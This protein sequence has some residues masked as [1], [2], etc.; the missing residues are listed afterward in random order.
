MKQN[1]QVDSEVKRQI[2]SN[3][4]VSV[5]DQ[6]SKSSSGLGASLA[7]PDNHHPLHSASSTH[8]DQTTSCP[9]TAVAYPGCAVDALH[10]RPNH[11]S[12]SHMAMIVFS[13]EPKRARPRTH[14][15]ARSSGIFAANTRS[16]PSFITF[17]IRRE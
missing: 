4:G 8:T 2:E 6:A 16:T 10:R 1:I 11:S 13:T 14:N 5:P 15:T 3:M 12:R 7:L 17:G 9:Q